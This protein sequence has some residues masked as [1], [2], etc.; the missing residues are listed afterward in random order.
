[1]RRIFLGRPVHWLVLAAVIGVLWWLGEAQMHTREFKPFLV[2][3][4][5][6]AAAAVAAV[7]ATARA[8]DRLTREP[9][10][11]DGDIGP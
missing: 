7:L 1:M 10:D 6:L 5:A 8:G 2:T 11:K 3:L 4:I 9:I